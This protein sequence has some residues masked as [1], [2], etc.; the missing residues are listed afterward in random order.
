LTLEDV[1][2]ILNNRN[3]LISL[4]QWDTAGGR[5]AGGGGT[6]TLITKDGKSI[7]RGTKIG[8][9]LYKIKV[10]VC[11]PNTTHAKG[12]TVTPQTF[13]SNE[14][15][16]NW[17]TWHN[18]FGHISYSGL[19]KL[20]D[21]NLVDG[22]SVDTRMPKPDC[23]ACTE[24]K[25]SQEPFSKSTD[26]TTEP[27]EL[28]HIDLWGKYDITSINGNQYYIVLVDDAARYTSIDFL[29]KK[30]EAAQK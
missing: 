30:D 17:E 24:A 7:A 13:M 26:R 4:G 29:K 12:H 16:Q 14:P 22:F 28:T 25:Q 15:S 10:S 2:Y 3:N 27:G 19:Q 23:V 8:N 11:K 9:N 1:L 6:L 21:L 5:Y 18:Q 20:L